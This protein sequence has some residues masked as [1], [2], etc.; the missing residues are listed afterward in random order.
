MH[1]VSALDVSEVVITQFKHKVKATQVSPV[2]V[3]ANI[4]HLSSIALNPSQSSQVGKEISFKRSINIG[5]RSLT[6]V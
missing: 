1:T 3:M 5:K 4:I 2:Q 6:L